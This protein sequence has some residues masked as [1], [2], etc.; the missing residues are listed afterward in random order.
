MSS[1]KENPSGIIIGKKKRTFSKH[2]YENTVELVSVNGKDNVAVDESLHKENEDEKS[3][4]EEMDLLTPGDLI[5]F[6]WQISKGMVSALK[7]IK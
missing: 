4:Q 2:K 7:L 3:I 6:G 1:F 5:A